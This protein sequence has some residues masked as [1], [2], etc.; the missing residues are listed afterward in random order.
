MMTPHTLKTSLLI[1]SSDFWLSLL[2]SLSLMLRPTVSRP[3]CLAIKHPSGAYDLILNVENV[4]LR[5]YK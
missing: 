3:V 1:S 4:N 2:P 5:G